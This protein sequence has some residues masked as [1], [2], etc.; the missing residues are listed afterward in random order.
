METPHFRESGMGSSWS[1]GYLTESISATPSSLNCTLDGQCFYPL[2]QQRFLDSQFLLTFCCSKDSWMV[3]GFVTFMLKQCFFSH[4]IVI[5]T[6]PPVMMLPRDI[7]NANTNTRS[8]T[9][10]NTLRRGLLI[11]ANPEA[12]TQL[13]QKHRK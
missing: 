1:A 12:Y 7:N 6:P 3:N 4:W 5:K 10:T 8:N 2:L 13:R 11:E 9:I